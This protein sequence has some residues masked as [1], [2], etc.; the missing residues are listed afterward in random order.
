MTLWIDRFINLWKYPIALLAMV[1]LAFLGK[2]FFIFIGKSFQDD[3]IYFW[4]GVITYWVLWK[5]LFSHRY[6]GSFLP[7]LIHEL[8]HGLIAI[9]TFHRVTGLMVGWQ[10]GGHI[11]YVGGTGNWLIT[12][13]PYFFPLAFCLMAIISF[14]IEIPSPEKEIFFGL[15]W[16]FE[17]MCQWKQLHWDQPDLHK[18]GFIFVGLFLP[19]AVLFSQCL[20]FGLMFQGISILP[21]L[22]SDCVAYN[23]NLI[24]WMLKRLPI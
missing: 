3:G 13:A 4:M 6:V 22:W 10:K 17:S 19:T 16:G 20:I 1:N 11:Q 21:E 14:V 15:I 24:R 18:V 8:I 9:L 7:T 23:E 2:K 12:I 5:I